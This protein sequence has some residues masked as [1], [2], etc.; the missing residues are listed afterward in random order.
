M[1]SLLAQFL[2]G[3]EVKIATAVFIDAVY[4]QSYDKTCA[5]KCS[6]LFT[7]NPSQRQVKAAENYSKYTIIPYPPEVAASRLSF[8]GGCCAVAQSMAPLEEEKAGG[9]KVRD[10]SQ[11]SDQ[12]V[13]SGNPIPAA[14][15]AGEQSGRSTEPAPLM[16]RTPPRAVTVR[17]VRGSVHHSAPLTEINWMAGLAAPWWWAL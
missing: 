11:H 6:E 15:K 3:P 2:S 10:Y 1:L 8:R 12:S 9:E 4:Q 16:T 5:W 7:G 17:I 14:V 13:V